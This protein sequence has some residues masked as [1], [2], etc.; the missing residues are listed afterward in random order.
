MQKNTKTQTLKD[1]EINLKKTLYTVHTI[2]TKNQ[3]RR[4][5]KNRK[6]L[7]NKQNKKS[8]CTD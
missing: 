4:I 3:K 5:N 6:K 8:N 1:T 2:C 7:T